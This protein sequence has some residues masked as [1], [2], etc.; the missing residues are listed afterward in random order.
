M[1]NDRG[2]IKGDVPVKP[3]SDTAGEC[4]VLP[5]AVVIVAVGDML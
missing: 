1:G 2:E 4:I 3:H 5:T